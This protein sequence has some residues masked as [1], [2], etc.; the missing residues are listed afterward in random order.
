ISSVGRPEILHETVVSLGKQTYLPIM[1]VLSLCDTASVA[2]ETAQLPLIRTV[3]GAQGLTKQ[4]NM[5]VTVVP[6]D[7]D[8]VL[9]LDDDIELS[10]NYIESMQ[11]LFDRSPDVVMASGISAADGLRIGRT[12]TRAEASAAVLKL[13]CESKTEA[14][15][16][17][18]GCNM[19]VRRS[20]LRRVQFDE[21]LPLESWLEDYDFSVRSKP[22]GQVVWNY[23]TC[24]AHIGAQRVGRERGF[25]VGYT[26][27]ANSHYL[28]RKGTIPSFRKLLRTFWLPA[29]RVSL[30]G[31]VHGKPPWNTLL[32]YKG[33]VRGNVRALADAAM[34][35]L[36]PER[37]LD[38][39]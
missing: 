33:R 8:C 34:F 30:Q 27:L 39:V 18:Y 6:D 23:E 35:R 17:A 36:K 12:L 13:R 22:Y 26:Q 11:R 21:R 2:K 14:A 7:A 24:V 9:F 19:F 29:L 38:F 3:Q 15:E 10:P 31:A 32:D 28:W 20:L 37:V 25:L 16:G 4:R 5:G 1:I